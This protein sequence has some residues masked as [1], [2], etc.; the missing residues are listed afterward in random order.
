MID[1]ET[2]LKPRL[3]ETVVEL[4]GVGQVRVRALSRTECLRIRDLKDDQAAME[5]AI[6]AL[7]LIEPALTDED[8]AAWHEQAV[9]GEVDTLLTAIQ[10][11]SAL[12]EGAA[13]SGVPA[14]R[15]GS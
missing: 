10:S 7:G 9:P 6:I 15:N 4:D 14:I 5:R 11:L 2:F 1:R 3:G 12:G 8:V 13:K